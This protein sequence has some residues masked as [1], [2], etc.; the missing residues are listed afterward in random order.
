M[1]ISEIFYSVQ[2]EGKNVGKPIVFIRTGGCNLRCSFCDSKYAFKGEEWSI[3]KIMDEVKKYSS[4]RSVCLTGGE[5]L[6]QKDFEDLIFE[7]YNA[8]YDAEIETNGTILRPRITC[9]IALQWNVSPKLSNS[10][11]SFSESINERALQSFNHSALFKFVIP[12]SEIFDEAQELISRL[13][14]TNVYLMPEGRDDLTLK[15]TAKWLVEKCK[16]YNYRFSPRLHVWLW[17]DERGV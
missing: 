6:L 1:Q 11:H 2:G 17:G 5:P 3:S 14:L 8:G 9:G 13:R 16:Q 15:K 12:N 10:G 7:L 4:C